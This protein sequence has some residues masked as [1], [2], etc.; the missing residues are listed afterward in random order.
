VFQFL[1]LLAQKLGEIINTKAW[2]AE[3]SKVS[4]LIVKPEFDQYK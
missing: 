4:V 3:Y 1:L 2:Q